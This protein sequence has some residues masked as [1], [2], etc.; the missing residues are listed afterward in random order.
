LPEPA[1][2]PEVR[3]VEVTGA[4]VRAVCALEVAPGQARFVAPNAASIAEAH[5]EPAG[6]FRA[7]TAAQ[8]LVGFV[9]LYDPSLPGVT[10][11]DPRLPPG[12]IM[13]WRFMIDAAAQGKGYGRA[14]IGLVAAHARARGALTLAVTYVDGE[15]GPAA[16]YARCGFVPT[17]RMLGGEAEAVLDL[18]GA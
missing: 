1:H 16:F 18:R 6:W 14:A 3:L 13:L 2:E 9:Q 7:V 4:T 17:G 8:R 12:C 5:F 11:A 15:G 10:E